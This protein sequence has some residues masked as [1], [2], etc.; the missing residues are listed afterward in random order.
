MIRARQSQGWDG[1]WV[2]SWIDNSQ[3]VA[4]NEAAHPIFAAMIILFVHVGV[5]Y[6]YVRNDPQKTENNKHV[7]QPNHLPQR[8]EAM[9]FF[10]REEHIY[11]QKTS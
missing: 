2:G 7:D 9:L 10:P 11:Q 3:S 1:P 5:S 8:H 4:L 6:L